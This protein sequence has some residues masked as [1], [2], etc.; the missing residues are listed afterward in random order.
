MFTSKNRM[1]NSNSIPSSWTTKEESGLH[2]TVSTS[3]LAH[4]FVKFKNIRNTIYLDKCPYQLRRA[5]RTPLDQFDQ[6]KPDARRSAPS[7]A[8]LKMKSLAQKSTQL[9]PELQIPPRAKEWT[10]SSHS[11]H[12]S[13]RRGT[14]YSSLGKLFQPLTQ[15]IGTDNRL[16][17]VNIDGGNVEFIL[18][19]DPHRQISWPVTAVRG[20]AWN[21]SR[22]VQ[23]AWYADVY[24]NSH[25]G[26]ATV[27]T[28]TLPAYLSTVPSLVLKLRAS[29]QSEFRSSRFSAVTF[30]F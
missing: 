23:D 18:L 4:L 14:F 22:T 19:G 2:W 26:V 11:V 28:C 8:E 6:S 21:F 15:L 12:N 27:L 7:K 24:S 20:G 9:V 5:D 1:W 3:E 25:V 30:P 10:V 16:T 13:Q 17:G 29:R